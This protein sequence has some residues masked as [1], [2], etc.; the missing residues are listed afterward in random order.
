MLT[1][2]TPRWAKAVPSNIE[3]VGAPEVNAPPWIQTITGRGRTG[4]FAG[5]QMLR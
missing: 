5:A 1:R 3:A 4:V 2:T